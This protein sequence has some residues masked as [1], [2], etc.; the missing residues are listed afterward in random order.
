MSSFDILCLRSL[1]ASAQE[2]YECVTIL[3][4][5]N[6]VTRTIIDPQ[7]ANAPT[8]TLPVTQESG[9]QAVEPTRSAHARWNP[10][11]SRAIESR[12]S[13]RRQPGTHGPPLEDCSLK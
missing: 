6:A 11:D 4:V 3:R 7:F 1:I 12:A 8:D 13:S 2:D 10:G 9:L 5:I